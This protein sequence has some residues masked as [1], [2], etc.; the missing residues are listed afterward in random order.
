MSSI[1]APAISRTRHRIVNPG[2]LGEPRGFSN[3]VVR[4]A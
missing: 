4:S 3:A 2:E 1:V